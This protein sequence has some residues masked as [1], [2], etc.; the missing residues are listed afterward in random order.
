M[1]ILRNIALSNSLQN[2]PTN[3]T[4]NITCAHEYLKI[5]VELAHEGS[6]KRGVHILQW[7]LPLINWC[8]GIIFCYS[9]IWSI[10]YLQ[11]MLLFQHFIQN[12]MKYLTKHVM[13]NVVH[14]FFHSKSHENII[15][16]QKI[17]Q[18]IK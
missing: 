17:I 15:Q 10:V 14:N 12:T 3:A 9:Y 13:K 6:L 16:K 2:V 11:K 8:A 5:I 7:N 18:T 1:Q 4:K